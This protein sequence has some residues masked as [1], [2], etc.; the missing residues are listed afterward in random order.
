MKVIGKLSLFFF[1]KYS[2]N[3][4]DPELPENAYLKSKT[5]WFVD[6]IY[7]FGSRLIYSYCSIDFI[8][9]SFLSGAGNVC[10]TFCR[11]VSNLEEGKAL[12]EIFIFYRISIVKNSLIV[13]TP[14][15]YF[16]FGILQNFLPKHE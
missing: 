11:C 1:Q 16:V 13:N 9:Y 2:H 10:K 5:W 7:I 6:Y 4:Q 3:Q 14:K 15:Y 12:L 8:L